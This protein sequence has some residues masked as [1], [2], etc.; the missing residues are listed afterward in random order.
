MVN[1]VNVK[2]RNGKRSKR[3]RSKRKDFNIAL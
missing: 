3:K 2:G 1:E